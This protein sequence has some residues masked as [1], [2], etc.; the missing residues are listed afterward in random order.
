MRKFK[1]PDLYRHLKDK[2]QLMYYRKPTDLGSNHLI[3][4]K[5][6]KPYKSPVIGFGRPHWLF[7]DED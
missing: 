7:D 1:M 2:S 3:T 6:N 5:R 4:K